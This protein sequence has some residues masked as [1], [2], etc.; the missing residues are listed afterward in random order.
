[1]VGNEDSRDARDTTRLHRILSRRS[2][3]LKLPTTRSPIPEGIVGKRVTCFIVDFV[4]TP[5][6]MEEP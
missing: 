3:C 5:E 6:D 4:V 1:M 2:R